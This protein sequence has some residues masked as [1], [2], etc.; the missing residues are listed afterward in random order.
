MA[1]PTTEALESVDPPT[2]VGPRGPQLTL[3]RVLGV[4]LPLAAVTAYVSTR[5]ISFD[6]AMNMQVALNLAENGHYARYFGGDTIFPSEIQTSSYF[7]FVT[8]AF[9]KVFGASTLTFQAGNLVFLAL[10]LAAVGHAVPSSRFL[11]LVTPS[12]ALVATPGLLSYSTGGYGEGAV[13]GLTLAAFVL[14]A[15]AATVKATYVRDTVLAF[16]LIGMA[17]SVKSIAVAAVPVALLALVAVGWRHG[18]FWRTAMLG[19]FAAAVPVVLFEIYRLAALGLDGYTG[20]WSY[21]LKSVN[22]Q[23]TGEGLDDGD[24]SIV[25]KVGDHFH[26]LGDQ[27]HLEPEWWLLLFVTLPIAVALLAWAA[28]RTN[29]L[30]TV[31]RPLLLAGYLVA[32]GTLYAAWWL[33]VTSTEKAWLRRITIG[34][35][36]SMLATVLL[37]WVAVRLI[38]SAA[39]PLDPITLASTVTVA[40]ALLATTVV[41]IETVATTSR[42]TTTDSRLESLVEVSEQVADLDAEG[43]ELFGIQWWSAPVVSLYSGVDFENLNGVDY[44]EPELHAL[45]NGGDAYLVWDYYA[46]NLWSSEPDGYGEVDYVLTDLGNEYAQIW[47][48]TLPA[49]A[50]AE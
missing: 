35:F 28:Y 45:I 47:R 29:R 14:L 10:L 33:G 18:R 15:R 6:G 48:I 50:C 4:L 20:W 7:L 21:H 34:I 25:A 42:S 8:A 11:V 37:A 49:G 38:R 31:L 39:N 30:G 24:G 3:W 40:L 23:A 27:T 9:I 5:A 41:A 43:A 26:L 44:C 46:I 19:A 17:V 12:L 1:A 22:V 36:V 16:L 2:E 32:Y 13:A